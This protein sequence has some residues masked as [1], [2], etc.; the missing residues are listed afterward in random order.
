MWGAPNPKAFWDRSA[1]PYRPD[2]RIIGRSCSRSQWPQYRLF[3]K[4]GSTVL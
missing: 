1:L 2:R 4:R 3:R